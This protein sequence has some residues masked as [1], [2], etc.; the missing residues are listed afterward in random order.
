[1]YQEEINIMAA[2]T[3]ESTRTISHGQPA[4]VWR[5]RCEHGDFTFVAEDGAYPSTEG[6]IARQ[7]LLPRHD[8]ESGRECT[9]KLWGRYLP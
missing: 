1:L 4:T 3:L 6:T 8:D 5:L 2:A 7:E 9:A